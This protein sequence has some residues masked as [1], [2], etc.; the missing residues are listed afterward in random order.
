[1]S[2]DTYLKRKN[3]TKYQ[4]QELDGI[5]VLITPVLSQWASRVE[6]DI[7]RFLFWKRFDVIADHAHRPT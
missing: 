6:V 7:D 1:M 5:E 3:L 2:V 4:T